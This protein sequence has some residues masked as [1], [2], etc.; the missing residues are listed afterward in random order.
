MNWKSKDKYLVQ[1]FS[2]PNPDITNNIDLLFRYFL[3]GF[4]YYSTKQPS[5]VAY[6]GARSYNGRL[7]DQMEG[8]S[9]TINL[10]ACW[11]RGGRDLK[12]ETL[13][14]KQFDILDRIR[15]GF[16]C[17]V[18][19]NSKGFW[20]YI[21]H[22]DQRLCEAAELALNLWLLKDRVWKSFSQ[23]EKELI[24][25]WFFSANGKKCHDSNWKMFR[26]TINTVFRDL[27]GEDILTGADEIHERVKSFYAGDGWFADGPYKQIDYY[28]AY[29]FHYY[30]QWINSIDPFFDPQF[31]TH[32]LHEKCKY[33]KYFFTPEGFPIFGRSLA[34]RLLT[35][36]P[37]VWCSW[38]RPDIVSPG[39]ALRATYEIWAHFIRKGGLNKGNL[40]QGYH[41]RNL[42]WLDNY[43]GPASCFWNLKSLAVPLEKPFDSEFW[44]SE[45][46]PLPIELGD[47]DFTIPSLGWRIIGTRK[48]MDVTII[49]HGLLRV[50][51][52]M[53]KYTLLNRL[54]G[55]LANKP[56]RP[57]NFGRKYAMNVYSSSRPFCLQKD[58]ALENATVPEVVAIFT[59]NGDK[60]ISGNDYLNKK[61]SR[62]VLKIERHKVVAGIAGK[63]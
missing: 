2:D 12:P 26:L 40:T 35:P 4:D 13:E 56:R 15:S 44:K 61:T 11:I 38:S 8:F 57:Y 3:T 1:A 59:G 62:K 20:G 7:I 37:L 43:S 52:P 32:I 47:F 9:R 30:Y 25:T 24:T 14:G 29:C 6:K 16:L 5:L 53:E 54:I 45:P 50:V 42:N 36:V 63:M 23:K 27:I 39:Q 22:N 60:S 49:R 10:F 33:Y 46:E 58:C 31:I 21:Q 48:H 51:F 17:G 41:R 18:N 28:N 34:Y 55:L 19:P